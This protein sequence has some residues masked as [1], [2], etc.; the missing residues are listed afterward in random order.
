MC[1]DEGINNIKQCT[2]LVRKHGAHHKGRVLF[3]LADARRGL[4]FLVVVLS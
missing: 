1:S 2:A 4:A 3:T